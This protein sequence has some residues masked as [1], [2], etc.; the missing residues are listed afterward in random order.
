MPI[1][2]LR[3]VLAARR[4]E[5]HF[6][7]GRPLLD[8]ILSEATGRRRAHWS[9]VVA[10]EQAAGPLRPVL[11]TWDAAEE[12][13]SEAGRF[14]TR[15]PHRIAALS[16]AAGCAEAMPGP[17]ASGVPPA[18][19][20]PADL[21]AGEEVVVEDAGARRGN[22]EQDVKLN[23]LQIL[24]RAALVS[25]SI[26]VLL[27][28]VAAGQA[29]PP[30]TAF[31]S[32][33]AAVDALLQAAES[34]D[35]DALRKLF[36]PDGNDV[37]S[38]GDPVQDK[39]HLAAFVAQ[40]REKKAVV[41]D[42][43]NRNRA[44]LSV[45]TDDWPFPIPLR[46]SGSKWAFDAKAGREE[47]V[48]RRIGANE[49]DAIEICHGFVDAQV[50]YALRAREITGVAQYAQR[51]F[52]TPGKRDG[53]YWENS[54]G[55]SG[56][57]ISA[58]IARAIQ[59]GYSPGLRSGYHGYYFSVLKGQGPAAQ[60]GELDYVIEG[61]MIGGFAL[62]AVPVEYGVT[63]IKTFMVNQSGIVYQKDLGSDSLNIGRKIERFNPDK[64]W[65]RTDD[66]WP[67]EKRGV[68]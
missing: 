66:E 6:R 62:L 54:D 18:P 8:R 39:N 23:S 3:T 2:R 33:Q 43:Q 48:M 45:G 20:V 24:I 47:I 34:N 9:E 12:I 13:E 22:R 49:L 32:P 4:V 61:I 19:G 56:G 55:K 52:S 7:T 41:V 64:T 38:S 31:D 58:A 27:S 25:T 37:V 11:A 65:Q 67:S 63:G 14:P 26:A 44:I 30:P 57:P 40:A 29:T 42:P 51:I 60:L 17:V 15:H 50:D 5:I 21:A 59:E 35:G 16:A 36:G 46:K 28:F 68:E 10:E 53:L 1:V